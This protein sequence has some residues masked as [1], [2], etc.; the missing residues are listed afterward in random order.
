MI[1]DHLN[2][3]V[4]DAIDKYL[5]DSSYTFNRLKNGFLVRFRHEECGEQFFYSVVIAGGKGLVQVC[6]WLGL[7]P[8][9]LP[10]GL[11]TLTNTLR[12]EHL[13]YGALG[14]T[15]NEGLVEVT[16]WLNQLIPQTTG[17]DADY[18]FVLRAFEVMHRD[19]RR[20]YEAVYKLRP[21]YVRNHM[22][23]S[24]P[25]LV[26]SDGRHLTEPGQSRQ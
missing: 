6:A 7:T 13:F 11:S 21:K 18:S 4:N 19:V 8:E 16:Y 24:R 23:K 3:S 2:F 14:E 15:E 5:T 25:T 1:S 17:F 12:T 22:V 26:W 9:E 10:E 20:F